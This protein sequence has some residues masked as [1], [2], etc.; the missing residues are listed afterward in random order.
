M[1]GTH[2]TSQVGVE[3]FEKK[4]QLLSNL[5]KCE[6]SQQSLVYFG[7]VICRG[8]LKINPINME[9]IITWLDPTNVIE[10]RIFVGATQYW[11]L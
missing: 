7:Y 2:F 6:F 9:A 11:F 8:K 10:V 1:G 4:Y 5:K 3:V